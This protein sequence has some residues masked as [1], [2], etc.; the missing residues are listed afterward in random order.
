M[1][2]GLIE[3]TVSRTWPLATGYRAVE[4]RAKQDAALPSFDEGAMLDVIV[5]A[6]AN[7]SRR[8]PLHRK[9]S[10]RETYV[11][12]VRTQSDAGVETRADDTMFRPG[13]E[14][15]VRPPTNLPLAVDERARYMLFAGGLGVAPIAGIA[16]RLADAGKPFE[17]HHFA[18]SSD[19]TLLRDELQALASFGKIHHRVGLSVDEIAQAVSHAL[20]PNGANAQ[21]YCSGPPRL[22]D[23]IHGH[24]SEW[25]YPRNI[26]K[27]YLGERNAAPV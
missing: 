22:M 11:V 18:Q 19:R 23:L 25:V 4:L 6:H 24:A 8:Q 10:R 16:Q 2:D 14:L 13:S 9:A 1:Y 15:L 21:V 17:L 5:D 26:H 20:S 12:G 7:R 27:I 3:V